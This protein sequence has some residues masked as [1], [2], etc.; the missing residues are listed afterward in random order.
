MTSIDIFPAEETVVLK[1]KTK[2]INKKSCTY[3]RN[4]IAENFDGFKIFT[5]PDH[6]IP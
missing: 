5:F 4:G 1:N 3:L 2:N 6:S